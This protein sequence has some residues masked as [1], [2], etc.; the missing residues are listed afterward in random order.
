L[1]VTASIQTSEAQEP[2]STIDP[3]DEI[4]LEFSEPLNMATI[5]GNVS[6][7]VV[8]T[9][10]GLVP[11]DPSVAVVSDAQM[12]NRVVIRTKDGSKLPS[13]EEYRLVV[14]SG[15]RSRGGATMAQDYIRYFA[16]DYDLS[17]HLASELGDNRTIT[18]VI[19]DIHLGDQRSIDNK[20]G[21]FNKN[22]AILLDFLNHLRQRPDVKELAIAGDLFDEWVTPMDYDTFNGA[23]QSGFVDMIAAANK[24]VIEAFN[25]II[26]DGNIKVTYV[27]GNH[28]MLVESGDIQRIFPGISQARDVQGLGTYTPSDLPELVIEHGHRYDF[29]NA[30]D[31]ISNR[32]ITG[33]ASILSPGFFVSKIAATSDLERGQASFYR[34]GLNVEHTS[35][36][37]GH[38]F[39][40]WAAWRLIMTQKPVK[41]SWNEKMIVTAVDGYTGIYS[42]YDLIPHY[43]SGS[44]PLDVTL[45]KG[46]IDTWNQR[47]A[48][49]KLPVPILAEV[50]IVAGALNPVL[51]DQATTQYF[52]N[53]SSNKRVV[54]FGHTHHADLFSV[55]NHKGKWSIYANSGTWVDNSKLSC[56][57]VAIFPK[58][59]N[60]AT[61][62]TVTVYQYVDAKNIQKI[63]SAAIR[64]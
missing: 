63:K 56:T 57:F 17:L 9:G 47:Q 49:N 26:N 46:I 4:F 8:K 58:K 44:G 10:G 22:S 11:V 24:P 41:D 54:V 23:S 3:P 40:Y 14:A 45:Y 39:S 27:P 13:G 32:S 31:P 16:T 12:P 38:Y 52:W 42:I 19:S 53:T 59:D 37:A 50:A 6:L 34:D 33:T 1:T 64:N 35:R 20:Y 43:E 51:D 55:L 60:G 61:T 2:L 5:E 48:I 15:I 28:D 30:P 21:W 18:I 25:N 62:D 7:Q 36:E 29:F